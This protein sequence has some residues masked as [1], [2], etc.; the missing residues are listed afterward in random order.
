MSN[1]LCLYKRDHFTESEMCSIGLKI[2][3]LY[4]FCRYSATVQHTPKCVENCSEDKVSHNCRSNFPQI[5]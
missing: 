4:N 3:T 5:F 2:S 1:K